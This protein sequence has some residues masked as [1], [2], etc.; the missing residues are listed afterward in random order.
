MVKVSYQQKPYRRI[1]MESFGAQCVASPS[2]DTNIGKSILEKDPS[3]S[4]S[5]GIAIS[6]ACE[7]AF[8]HDD[9]KYALGSVLNH[10]L[11]HQT[12]LGLETRIQLEKVDSYPDIVIGCVGGGSNFAGLAF[13]FLRD[14]LTG[15]NQKIQVIAVE[16]DA[17]PS[18][19]K[20]TYTWDFGDV[21]GMAPIT[22]M[23]TLGHDF[24]PSSIHAGGLRYHGMSPLVSELYKL[25]QIEARAVGQVPVFDSALK[26]ARAEGIVPAPESSHAV[27]VA[28]DEAL[29]CR[30]SGESKTIVFSLSGHGYF[31]LTAYEKYLNKELVD[32]PFSEPDLERSLKKLPKVNE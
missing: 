22:K 28:M 26:F 32:Q 19:T 16:P 29:K 9:T 27:K 13:P 21:A 5:L 23:Y 2:M 31:D 6:E 18:L 12:V 20:G 8:A 11:L 17:C 7:D 24:I 10:V 25:G 1:L 14:K 3:C 30:E 15:K 4:G